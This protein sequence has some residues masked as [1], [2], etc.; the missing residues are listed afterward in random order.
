M[1]S[2]HDIFTEMRL[3]NK[4]TFNISDWLTLREIAEEKN[5]TVDELLKIYG[6]EETENDLRRINEG[7]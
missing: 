7:N 4:P 2:L 6:R 1:E 5:I 3:A